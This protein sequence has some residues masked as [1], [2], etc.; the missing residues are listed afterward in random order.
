ML[1]SEYNPL[2]CWLFVFWDLNLVG[3]IRYGTEVENYLEVYLKTPG[4]SKLDIARALLARGN[5]RKMGGE[6]LLAKAEQGMYNMCSPLPST[7]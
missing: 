2:A 7:L 1:G 4:L 5:A 3:S 6:K